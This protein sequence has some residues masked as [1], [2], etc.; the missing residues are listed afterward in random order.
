MFAMFEDL[1]TSTNVRSRLPV[2]Y[3][4]GNFPKTADGYTK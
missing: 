1:L 4:L 2:G 3:W